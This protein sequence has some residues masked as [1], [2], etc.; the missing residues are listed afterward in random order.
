MVTIG[1]SGR[2]ASNSIAS[3]GVSQ[4]FGGGSTSTGK[5]ATASSTF[6]AAG[7]MPGAF[8]P[9]T[10]EKTMTR[11]TPTYSSNAFA[12]A[13]YEAPVQATESAATR[14]LKTT[15]TS[16]E[17]YGRRNQP[18]ERPTFW[19]TMKEAAGKTIK[20][21]VVK[22]HDANCPHCTNAALISQKK[23]TQLRE[24]ET[25]LTFEQQRLAAA[26]AAQD[27]EIARKKAEREANQREMNS[28]L[29][30]LNSKKRAEWEAKKTDTTNLQQTIQLQEENKMITEQTLKERLVGK[31]SY[32]DELN[33]KRQEAIQLN[34]QG[35][36]SDKE[37]ER[38]LNGLQFECYKRDPLMKE[39]TKKTGQFVRTQIG[40]TNEKKQQEKEEFVKPP[41][42]FY[43]DA[44]LAQLKAEA[45][46]RNREVKAHAAGYAKD[47]LSHHLTKTQKEQNERERAIAEERENH[48]RMRE[49]E[50]QERENKRRTRDDRNYEMNTVVSTINQQK[51]SEWDAKKNDKT[52][53][54]ETEAL[55]NETSQLTR[56]AME[57]QLRMKQSYNQDLSSLTADQRARLEEQQRRDQQETLYARGLRFECYSRDPKMKEETRQTGKFQKAQID[58]SGLKKQQEKESIVMP[59]PSL[60]TTQDL[61]ALE[62][63]AVSQDIEKRASLGSVM[64]SQ[65]H[66]S[67]SEKQARI[68]EERRKDAENAARLAERN[69]EIARREREIAESNKRNYNEYLGYQQNE[70]QARRA[71]ETADRRYD[72]H[73]ERIV[74]E[75]AALGERIVKCHN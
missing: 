58:H 3:P 14:T 59:P 17:D 30:E 51:A 10:A 54:L 23:D 27:A 68:A 75:N 43:T 12:H 41:E 66:E 39:E 21:E 35:R 65:Y 70:T 60:M 32:R 9:Q 55:Q 37:L 1:V 44:E 53:K 34:I 11:Y 8:R 46:A 61:K 29:S 36:I 63:E 40:M 49:L 69:A 26:Q 71:Q 2:G 45:E 22:A 20:R 31:L 38:R 73:T 19:Q 42:V 4:L 13:Q 7:T 28:T 24:K 56:Q 50:Q 48:R 5:P 15:G 52:N 74:E 6:T 62:Q 47:L 64:K 72:P 16:I 25:T 67:I 33:Q 57:D 18:F